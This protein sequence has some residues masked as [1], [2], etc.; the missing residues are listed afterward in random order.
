MGA[1]LLGY[2]TIFPVKFTE[3]E[4]EKLNKYIN[5]IDSFLS[6]PN[7]ADLISKE[8]S[9]DDTYLK[10][11]NELVPEIAYAIEE[12]GYHDDVE[13]ID[14]LINTFKD[15]IPEA[16]EFIEEPHICER[17]SSTRVIKLL[18][19]EIQIVFA[20]EMSWG[21]EPEG[22]GYEKLKSL[23][24]LGIL[25]EIERLTIPNSR[26]IHFIKEET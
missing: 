1:D 7:L 11:L 18:G 22:Y 3:E 4:L 8:E 20:G 2:Q 21:E 23:D 24:K 16:R 25:W 17:D 26:S 15:Y 6:T 10:Q 13:E 5:R 19:R 9:E 14:S 12:M